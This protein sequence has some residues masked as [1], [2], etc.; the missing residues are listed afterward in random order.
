M[1]YAIEDIAGIIKGEFLSN[2]ENDVIEHLIPDSRK[3]VFPA[4]SLFFALHG[5]RRNGHQ[6]IEE[7][8]GRG[9]YNFVVSEKIPVDKYPLSNI[10]YVKD[11]LY[12][13]QTLAASHR[14]RFSIP[15]IGLTGSNGKTIVKE[16]L[17]QLLENQYQIVK[18]PKSY[19]SQIGVPLSVWQMNE[20][21]QLAI[22][23]AGISETNEMNRLEKIIQP[24]IGVFTNIGEA[25]SEGFLNLRQKVN[26]KLQLFKNVDTLIYCKD[27]PSINEGIASYIRKLRDGI[28][29]SNIDIFSWSTKTDATLRVLAIRKNEEGD[30]GSTSISALYKEQPYVVKIPF[31]DDASVENAI[32]CLCTILHLGLSPDYIEEQLSR[33]AH[34]AMRLE[35]KKA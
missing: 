33:L 30:S 3:L 4:T 21:H 16:W 24:T 15:V 5:P 27:Y 31:T 6:F 18:N 25:H 13:L 12:A 29:A 34:V 28:T 1:K 2:H 23:E 17:Y 14:K 32:T 35:L 22:F 20:S 26:E 8:Y 10:I 11:S 7:L 9:V 19:N